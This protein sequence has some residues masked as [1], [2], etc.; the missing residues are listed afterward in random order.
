MWAPDTRPSNLSPPQSDGVLRERE[1]EREVRW[2]HVEASPKGQARVGWMNGWMNRWTGKGVD[3]CISGR[4][5]E[6]T[7][8]CV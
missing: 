5:T 6:K 4:T 2:Q 1:K 3:E 7:R 8:M